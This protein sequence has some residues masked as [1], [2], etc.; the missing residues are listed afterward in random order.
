F[1]DAAVNELRIVDFWRHT[2]MSI[3]NIRRLA[4]LA[5][6]SEL[7]MDDRQELLRVTRSEVE[8]EIQRLRHAL[9]LIDS[10]AER[11]ESEQFSAADKEEFQD[12]DIA[13]MRD[14]LSS[15]P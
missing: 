5:N 13:W 4:V 9:E 15:K 8:A 3:E 2:G 7:D 14:M 11:Y 6:N 10:F 1:D 12:A